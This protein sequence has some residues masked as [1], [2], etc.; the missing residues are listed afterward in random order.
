[1]LVT[2][3]YQRPEATVVGRHVFYNDSYFDTPGVGCD[4]NVNGGEPCNDDTA[5]ASD[6]TA[7]LPGGG[8]ATF[9]NYI[10]YDK[11][12][13]GIMIDVAGRDET[14]GEITA[15]DFVFTNTGRDGP[16]PDGNGCAG[17]GCFNDV[18]AAGP[19][20]EVG[21]GVT[22]RVGE[23]VGGSDR[24]VIT[25]SNANGA[26][27]QDDQGV[28]VPFP[29]NKN[30]WL[31][32]EVLA[33]GNTCIASPDV[34]W[35]GVAQGEG[36]LGNT[37]AAFPVAAGDQTVTRDCGSQGPGACGDQFTNPKPV[38][39]PLDYDKNGLISQAGDYDVARENPA[40]SS[41]AQALRAISP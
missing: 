3:P 4:A 22:T 13:N 17:F 39:E 24:V 8:P 41:L 14:C 30:A 37:A 7:L 1:L 5:I 32:V 25:W 27:G 36:N 9:A 10:S 20:A 2:F 23:G 33:N 19:S 21:S 16:D 26:T 29:N 18:P 15:A 12:I 38:T 11:G 35:F 31:Q 34:F 28:P 40:I 6:K